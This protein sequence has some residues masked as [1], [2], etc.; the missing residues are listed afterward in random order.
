MCLPIHCFPHVGGELAGEETFVFVY[1]FND[2]SLAKAIFVIRFRSYCMNLAIFLDLPPEN[3][4]WYGESYGKEST[5]FL[6]GSIIPFFS[7]RERA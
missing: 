2:P 3:I 6:L 5:N 4:D 1:G 7:E